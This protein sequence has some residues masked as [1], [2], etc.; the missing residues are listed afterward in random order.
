MKKYVAPLVRTI[1]LNVG[2]NR[3]LFSSGVTG[4]IPSGKSGNSMDMDIE[5]EMED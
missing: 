1:S 2:G 5:M 3:V 4:S